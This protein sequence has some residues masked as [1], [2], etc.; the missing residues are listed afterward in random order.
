M[1]DISPMR[2]ERWRAAAIPLLLLAGLFFGPLSR[3]GEASPAQIARVAESFETALRQ[4]QDGIETGESAISYAARLLEAASA[5]QLREAATDGGAPSARRLAAA[6]ALLRVDE[7]GQA[8]AVL[9]ELAFA[10]A[11]PLPLRLAA[12][13]ALG[14]PSAS[15]D[16]AVAALYSL[17]RYADLPDRVRV[18]AADHLVRL[19]NDGYGILDDLRQ[20]AS[21]PAARAEALLSLAQTGRYDRLRDELRVLSQEPGLHGAHARTLLLL[22]D[23]WAA[24]SRQDRYVGRVLAEVQEHIAKYYAV[25]ATDPDEQERLDPKNIASVVGRAMLRSLDPHN[26]FMDDEDLTNLDAMLNN[27]Y[28]GIGAWVGMRGGRFTILTPM[29]ASPAAQAGIRPLDVVLRVDD[30]SVHG[31][32][33]NDIIKM[34]KGNPGSRVKIQIARRGWEKPV[35]FTLTRALI[36][37]DTVVGQMLPGDIAYVRI[38]SFTDGDPRA[39]VRGTAWKLA[40][41]LEN[42]DKAGAK[43]LVLDLSGNPGGVLVSAVAVTRIFLG[44]RKLAV[45]VKYGKPA[46]GKSGEEHVTGFRRSL[47]RDYRY[48]KPVVVMINGGTASAG[49]IVAGALKDHGRAKLVGEKTF[50]KGSVQ[51]LFDLRSTSARARVKLTIAHWF[52]PSGRGLH[53]QGIEPDVQVDEPALTLG[54]VEARMRIRDQHDVQFWLEEDGR[55]ARER[56]RLRSLLDFDG[57]DADQYPDIDGLTASL[58]AKYPRMLIDRDV[59]RKEIRYGVGAYMREFLGESWHIDPQESFGLQEALLVLAGEIGG[60]PDL[61]LYARMSARVADNR[62][63][64]AEERE[65]AALESG[66]EEDDNGE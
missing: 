9:S 26:D 49:E 8:A 59:V 37:L 55:W 43:G 19:R 2:R 29:Y 32:K 40:E 10:E 24:D 3:A 65:M 52:L 61:P 4:A 56:E 54:E 60:L 35:D 51:Q 64:A 44:D 13:R 33:Q 21:S 34:L 42:F 1:P 30:A 50:G 46:I 62:R 47:D 41:M 25:D 28:G 5:E 45:S 38:V 39:R 11:L 16:Q 22:S 53:R 63:R 17:V 66:E 58:R 18:A 23:A 31:M 27:S 36:P 57:F 14:D 20:N 7:Q 12:A 48:H 15:G 6:A